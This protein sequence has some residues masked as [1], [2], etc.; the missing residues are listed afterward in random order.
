MAIAPAGHATSRGRSGQSGS[1]WTRGCGDRSCAGRLRG[2]RGGGERVEGAADLDRDH[3]VPGDRRAACIAGGGDAVWVA[4][5]DLGCA[6]ALR[7]LPRR[8]EVGEELGALGDRA[9]DH[10][11]T[12]L[13]EGGGDRDAGPVLPAA[14]TQLAEGDVVATPRYQDPRDEL[15]LLQA[16]LVV[17]DDQLGDGNAPQ[18]AHAQRLDPGV[19]R[20]EHG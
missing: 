9:D 4:G 5:R 19:E 13:A 2:E 18:A 20:D 1:G 12:A 11:D 16:G 7:W 14:G 10:R 15:V 6:G 3:P 8:A 17:A